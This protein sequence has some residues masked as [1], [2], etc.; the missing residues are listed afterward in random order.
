MSSQKQ[1][2]R[3]PAIIWPVSDRHCENCAHMGHRHAVEAD[4]P[5]LACE[6]IFFHQWVRLFWTPV[7]LVKVGGR[8]PLY[9]RVED[10]ESQLP[11]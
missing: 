1:G 5:C 4:S 2:R 3:E 6:M 10:D 11:L 9:I 8:W 7:P